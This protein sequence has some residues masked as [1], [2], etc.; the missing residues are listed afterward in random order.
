MVYMRV[1]DKNEID[2]F[3]LEVKGHPVNFFRI[4]TLIEPAIHKDF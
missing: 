1:S 3:R 2:I 4:F